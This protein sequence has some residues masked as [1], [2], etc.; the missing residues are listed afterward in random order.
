MWEDREPWQPAV[1][2]RR[3]PV[4]WWPHDVIAALRA[5]GILKDGERP[6]VLH[7][8]RCPFPKDYGARCACP[9]GPEIVW[10]DYDELQPRRFYVTPERFYDKH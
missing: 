8:Y 7:C 10:P 9:G 6:A 1:A 3:D 4:A 5:Q 2:P